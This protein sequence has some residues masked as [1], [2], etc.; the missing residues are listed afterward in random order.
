M[1]EQPVQPDL[2]TLECMQNSIAL[3]ESM[4]VDLQSL[5]SSIIACA[6]VESH[7]LSS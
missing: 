2:F 3:H 4:L 6:Q 1:F 5:Q 7:A